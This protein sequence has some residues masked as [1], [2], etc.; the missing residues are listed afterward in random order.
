LFGLGVD[1]QGGSWLP[2]GG[3]MKDMWEEGDPWSRRAAA[4]RRRQG[5][6]AKDLKRRALRISSHAINKQTISVPHCIAK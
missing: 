2:L 6:G 1:R 3:Q 4:A 5:Q